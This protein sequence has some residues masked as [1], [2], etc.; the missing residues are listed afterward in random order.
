[1]S[2]TA[3]PTQYWLVTVYQDV[4]AA[5]Q[6]PYPTDEARNQAAKDYRADDDC[7][8]PDGLHW[9]DIDAAGQ[10]SMGDY[11]GSFFA[12]DDTDAGTD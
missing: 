8:C 6:G 1:M 4:S 12:E 10:P 5:L 11:S 7:D 3:R 2:E 9:L